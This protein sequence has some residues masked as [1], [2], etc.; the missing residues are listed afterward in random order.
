MGST[1]DIW[2]IGSGCSVCGRGERAQ[3]FEGKGAVVVDG[4]DDEGSGGVVDGSEPTGG[5]CD[6]VAPAELED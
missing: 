4:A 5:E 2:W 6:G 1:V 3:C